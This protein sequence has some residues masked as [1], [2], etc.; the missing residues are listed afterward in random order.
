MG[1]HR[2]LNRVQY[3]R[4]LVHE[5]VPLDDETSRIIHMAPV[6]V[7]PS[8]VPE[9]RCQTINSRAADPKG[10][11]VLYWMTAFRRVGWNFALQR[12]VD[13]AR[14]LKKPLLVVEVL[15]CGNRWDSDRHHQFVL[16]GMAYNARQLANRPATYYPFVE[17]KPGDA[18]KLLAALTTRSCAV[19][20]DDF[21]IPSSEQLYGNLPVLAEMVDSNGLLPLRAADRVFTVAHAFRRFLQKTLPD[22]LLDSPR[23]NPLAG[24][25]LPPPKAV[26]RDIARQWPA[27]GRGLLAGQAASLAKRPINHEVRPVDTSGGTGAAQ[28]VLKRF[29]RERL[30]RY[31]GDRNRLQNESCS[32]L[33]PYM[34]FGH[35]ST[36]E[37]F[38]ALMKTEQW[39]PSQMADRA[40]GKREGWWGMSEP[41]EAFLDEL[42]TWREIGFNLCSKQPDY[43]AYDSL[44][45]WAKKTL[46]KHAR[47]NRLFVYS[48]E[49]FDSAATHDP[50][51]NAA[52]QQLV[53]EGRMHNYLRM[54]WGKKILE[55]TASPR[56]ALEVMIELNN[57]YA[58]D[59]RDPNS[60]SG[61]FW[62]L[63]RFDRAWG[64]ER[65]VFGTVRYMSSQCTA[66]KVGWKA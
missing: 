43:D 39:S 26:P 11:F 6:I 24:A 41:A 50:L 4:T 60:Y 62:V 48:I 63:G 49:E 25:R 37:I 33:S 14:C 16:E 35:I 34:H 42:I 13:W 29:L 32:R 1:H 51:W 15:G 17:S 7:P 3:S 36:H 54:L 38:H 27:A 65:P 12:A 46:A 66:R 58:L 52:Q 8:D 61:I 9:I 22:C 64:P 5:I 30:P 40:T 56:E 20:G 23:P 47:D 19:V 53:R 10:Q 59:G 21:P 18:H 55:W 57:K 45:A 44:P 2:I 31:V 28:A